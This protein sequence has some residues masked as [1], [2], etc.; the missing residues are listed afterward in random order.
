MSD[1]LVTIIIPCYQQG[2]FLA[3]ALGSALGQTHSA[4]EAIVV[5]DGSTDS[6]CAVAG[7][8]ARRF[9]SR[10]TYLYQANQGQHVARQCGLAA[11]CGE[12]C[13][14][15]DADDL[16][17][18]DAVA[19]CLQVFAAHP[20]ADAVAGNALLVGPDGQTPLGAHHQARAVA[21]PEVLRCNPY[22]VNLGV[23]TRTRSL[24]AAGGL[25]FERS[26]CEDWAVWCRMARCGMRFHPVEAV[27]GRYR[28]TG[29]NHSRN[30]LNNLDAYLA[31]LD[32][33]AGDDPRL[34]GQ[35][36]AP[37]VDPDFYHACRNGRVFY[38]LGMALA[39]GSRRPSSPP[40]WTG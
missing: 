39:T 4:T 7:D 28:Q 1:S 17:E 33:A 8:F 40:C 37:P 22:G 5:D 11:A 10:V 9:P 6:T 31:M 27:L 19:H 29:Q 32:L 25:G 13:L 3:E 15:L 35:P 14:M 21:W 18:P 16:L 12:F 26:G 23:M 20:E 34:A 38:S 36:A 2:H 24:R 30:V